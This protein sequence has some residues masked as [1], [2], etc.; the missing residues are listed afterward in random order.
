MAPQVQQPLTIEGK[1]RDTREALRVVGVSWLS[2]RGVLLAV[3]LLARLVL[4]ERT[5]NE[6]RDFVAFPHHPLWDSFC[7]W[8]SGW[9]D[10]IARLGYLRTPGQQSDVVFFPAFPFLSRWLAPVLGGHWAAGLVVGNLAFLAALFFVHALAEARLG[11][12][13]ARRAVGLVL[14]YPASLFYS[15]YYTEGLFLFAVAGSFYFYERDRL[16]PAS[17]LGGLAALTRGVGVVLLPAR[18][19]GTLARDGWRRGGSPRLLS[20]A[21]IP[22]GLGAFMALLYESVGDPW[23]FMRGEADFGCSPT[24]PWSTVYLGI[25]DLRVGSVM[26]WLD[27]AATLGLLVAAGVALRTKDLANAIFTLGVVLLPLCAGRVRSMERYSACAPLGFLLL[28]RATRHPWLARTLF[29][30][31]AALLVLQTVLFASW[32]WAG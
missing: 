18:L 16:L 22:L 1:R 11:G 8:D 10:R 6:N 12:D 14:V 7:R 28:A 26:E 17:L 21:L 30:A 29:P 27:L 20:L 23:A 5:P 19:V 9:Y 2:G 4:P 25:R 31:F 32:Y 13:G 3:V 15:A 24:L